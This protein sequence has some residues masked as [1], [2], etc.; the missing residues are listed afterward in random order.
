M[1]QSLHIL[2]AVSTLEQQL[3]E[4]T[5]RLASLEC[6]GKTTVPTPAPAKKPEPMEDEDDDDDDIDL[7]GSDDEE[8]S[9]AFTFSKHAV[10]VNIT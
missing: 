1:C 6:G 9:C 8:V 3:L 7:F 4:V 2:S 10:L 5:K